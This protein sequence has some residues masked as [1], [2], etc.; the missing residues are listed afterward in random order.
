LNLNTASQWPLSSSLPSNSFSHKVT[1]YNTYSSTTMSH[2]LAATDPSCHLLLSLV[3]FSG[4]GETETNWYVGHCWPIVPAPA[5]WWLWSSRWNE[6][7]Q[8]TLKYSE[9]TCPSATLSTTNPTWPD[10][11]S[12]PGRS[13]EKPATNHLSY[14]TAHLF[15]TGFLPLPLFDLEDRGDTFLRN[16]SRLLL[17]Y[18]PQ[19]CAQLTCVFPESCQNAVTR[20]LGAGMWCY[21]YEG[22][23]QTFKKRSR[24]LYSVNHGQSF[25]NILVHLEMNNLQ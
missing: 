14:G 17:K 18:N 21:L 25:R 10:L 23:A 15:H 24:S 7:W 4:W 5:W 12:N 3:S 13:G 9:K 8:G 22:R 19:D 2:I 20:E 1:N 11:G 6:D 16:I